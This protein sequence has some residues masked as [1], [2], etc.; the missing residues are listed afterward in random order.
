MQE[1]KASPMDVDS[2]TGQTALHIMVKGGLV[3]DEQADEFYK[4]VADMRFP[5]NAKDSKGR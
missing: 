4:G 3:H 1:G 5:N 2:V